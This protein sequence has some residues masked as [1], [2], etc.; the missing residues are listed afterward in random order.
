MSLPIVYHP[1]YNIGLCGLENVLHSFDTKKYGRI[2]DSLC[3]TFGLNAADFH[4][5]GPLD[6]VDLHLVHTKEYLASLHYSTTVA[7][8]AEVPPLAYF[9]SF[10]VKN[11]ILYPMKLATSGT[12]LASQ[13][14]LEHGWAINLSG[15]YHH[16][17][18]DRG[19][20]FCVYADIPLAIRKL[21]VSVDKVLIVD[22]DAH[23][24][25]GFQ[26]IFS[27]IGQDESGKSAVEFV[28]VPEVAILDMYNKDVYPHDSFA[29]QFIGYKGEMASGTKDDVYLETLHH[30]L[31]LAISEHQ[32]KIVFYNAGTDI[33]EHD[34]LGGLKI[35]REGIIA[36]DEFVFS[37]CRAR[38][39]PVVMVLSGGYTRESANI[40]SSSIANLHE[41]GLIKLG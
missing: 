35:S 33:Y 14:A 41:K 32:P 1:H 3:S 2:H 30:L 22:L 40:I 23:Q 28:P 12:I 18:A 15:G 38:N 16:A 20:G 39:I 17:K 13:L 24:G 29:K 6:A 5:P 7:A 21:P 27:A 36:R 37:Q 31:P 34:P 26:T 19:E 8:I 10:L 11:T 9:P 25:N 4:S